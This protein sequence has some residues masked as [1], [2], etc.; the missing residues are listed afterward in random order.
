MDKRFEQILHQR[1]YKDVKIA[2]EKMFN[3]LIRYI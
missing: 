1:R 3:I 2:H